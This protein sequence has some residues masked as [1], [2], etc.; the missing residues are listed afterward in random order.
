MQMVEELVEQMPLTTESCTRGG[1]HAH[2]ARQA[3]A[4]RRRIGLPIINA[5]VL[6]LHCLRK[7]KLAGA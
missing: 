3:V 1:D 6:C 5:F 2:L 4:E 7:V